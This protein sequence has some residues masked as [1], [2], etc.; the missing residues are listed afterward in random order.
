MKNMTAYL[1]GPETL[2]VRESPMPVFGD[3][4]VLVEM[5]HVGV[6]G[7]DVS[8]YQHPVGGSRKIELPVVL[9]HEC[10][11]VIVDT[12]KNVKY[13]KPGDRVALE[14]GIPCYH[15]ELCLSGKYNLCRNVVFMAA[16]PFKSAALHKYVAHPQSFA[17]KLPD[18][19]STIEGAMVEP[20]A[21]GFHSAARAGAGPGDSVII[22]GMGTIGLTVL[23]AC[24]ARGVSNITVVDVF[25]NRLEFAA[26]M[27]ATKTINASREDVVAKV[28]EQTGGYGVDLVFET[29]G[30]TQTAAMTADLVI[31]GGKV[32]L[33]GNIHGKTEYDF[34]KVNRKEIDILL[35]FRYRNNYPI[36]IESIASGRTKVN[37]MVT[38]KFP[39]EQV[40]QAFDSALND[41]QNQIKVIV[42]F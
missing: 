34:L 36:V 1:T 2:E 14:P 31:Y 5:K 24:Q 42:E 8:F 19:M 11:G 7:S 15:C 22:L 16:W 23:L 39:L 20:L 35:V 9:G 27:G 21:V 13:L 41:K 6:C 33:V 25:D 29:A 40:Q 38:A 17:F 18:N 30:N 12:G 10:A 3:D 28:M 32:I 4:D 37:D 26:K